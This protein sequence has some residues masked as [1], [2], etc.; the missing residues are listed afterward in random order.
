MLAPGKSGQHQN[1]Q[2]SEEKEG[3]AWEKGASTTSH[4]KTSNISISKGSTLSFNI[5]SQEDGENGMEEDTVVPED[6]QNHGKEKATQGNTL[7]RNNKGR[8][9]F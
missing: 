4:N 8:R 5:I 7:Q 2:E 3:K 6:T 9:P 1:K